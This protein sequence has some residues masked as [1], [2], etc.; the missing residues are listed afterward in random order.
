MQ[1]SD[2]SC[3]SEAFSTGLDRLLQRHSV[4]PKWLAGPGPSAVHLRLAARVA[5]RAPDHGRL[6]PWRAVVIG[7]DQ[8]LALGECFAAFARAVGK[9]EEAVAQERTRAFN[10]STLVAWIARIDEG[11]PEIPVHEQ[12][13]A[14]GGALTHFLSALH[15]MGFAGKTLSGHKCRHPAVFGAFCQP[16]ER[17]VAFLCLGTPRRS[18]E[19]RE[20]DDPDSVLSDWQCHGR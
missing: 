10:G 19:A 15:L 17:L 9:D 12:W 4:G 20:T 2:G 11:H 1:T 5:L 16:G 18:I 3:A 6:L 14:V 7:E 8:R 13:M